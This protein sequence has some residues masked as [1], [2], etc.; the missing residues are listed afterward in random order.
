MAREKEY[1]YILEVYQMN[2]SEARRPKD[3]LE[4]KLSVDMDYV[5]MVNETE[6]EGEVE[7]ITIHGLSFLIKEAYDQVRE[8]WLAPE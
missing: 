2:Q 7:I 6:F 1:T 5:C 4:R 3:R 8:D